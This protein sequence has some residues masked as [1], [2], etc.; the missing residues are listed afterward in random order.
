MASNLR[1]ATLGWKSGLV[2]EGGA[3][4]GPAVA[5]DSDGVA[6]P[7][8]TVTLLL[9]AAGCSGVDVVLFLKKMRVELTSFRIDVTGTRREED[10][11]RY[12]AIHFTYQLA[13]DQL[14]E[15]KARRAIDLSL[16]KYCSVIHS[17]APDIRVSY[18]LRLG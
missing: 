17:L 10:P 16:G 12:T 15:T 8:P 6:G 13:G 11:K 3:P 4:G 14:D 5:I 18:D 9:A 2:F 1:H 7:S